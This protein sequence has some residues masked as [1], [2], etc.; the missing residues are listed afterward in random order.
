MPGLLVDIAV[1]PGQEVRAGE[2]LA[3][4]EAM[5]ME[6]ILTA[7]QDGTV[8]EGAGQQGREPGGRPADP[9][10]CMTCMDGKPFKMLGIQQIAIGGPDKQRLKSLWVDMLGLTVKSTFVSER[11]N[12][13]EDICALGSG[14]ARGR[15]RPD[16][17]ARPRQEAGRARHAAEPRRPVGRRPARARSSG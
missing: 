16:A 13:D 8:A 3:V 11:E 2:R 14:R 12:V 15:G 10:L 9:E 7:A 4:I 6:N 1:K 17:A 5:K